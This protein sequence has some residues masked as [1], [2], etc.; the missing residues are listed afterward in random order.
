ML[1]IF[2]FIILDDFLL[3]F[4]AQASTVHVNLKFNFN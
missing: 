1:F 3:D 4:W 2:V